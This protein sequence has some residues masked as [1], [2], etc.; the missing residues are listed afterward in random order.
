MTKDMTFQLE[1]NNASIIEVVSSSQSK[2]RFHDTGYEVVLYNI[3]ILRGEFRDRLLP[4][5]R[6]VGFSGGIGATKSVYYKTWHNMLERCYSWNYV[7][8]YITY[9]D[10]DVAKD[11]HDFRIFRAWCEKTRPV[12]GSVKYE[13]DKDMKVKENTVY[14]ET[15]CIWL[16]KPLNQYINSVK[17]AVS[18]TGVKGVSPY[19]SKGVLTGEYEVRCADGEGK[20]AFLGLVSCV[21]EGSRRYKK[22]KKER[23]VILAERYYNKQQISLEVLDIIKNYKI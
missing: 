4:D 20:R 5:V 21:E 7:T 14:S 18:V 12:V 19:K 23:L 6:G 1:K 11:W 15:T 17:G 22:Y 2:V 8:K 13:L 10:C 16:P 9:K 3:N